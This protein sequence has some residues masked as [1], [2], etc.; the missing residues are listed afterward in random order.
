MG[1]EVSEPHNLTGP[2]RHVTDTGLQCPLH[3]HPLTTVLHWTTVN[4]HHKSKGS[5]VVSY[6]SITTTNFLCPSCIPFQSTKLQRAFKAISP[7]D[8]INT[9][10]ENV[11]L[12]QC[13]DILSHRS[14]MHHVPTSVVKFLW[15][16][17]KVIF[18]LRIPYPSFFSSI[19]EEN[20][21][22]RFHCIHKAI[23][24]SDRR[25]WK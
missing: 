8:F 12:S 5:V 19:H 20:D 9:Q 15:S 10:L 7:K 11:Y 16:L 2:S 4:T 17:K 3:L 25:S 22:Q 13:G 21:E 6:L 24:E 18:K 1:L 23:P 14:R